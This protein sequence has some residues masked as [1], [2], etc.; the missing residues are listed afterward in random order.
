M[1]GFPQG[2]GLRDFVG[3]HRGFD[4]QVS[5]AFLLADGV[6]AH[7]GDVCAV[8]DVGCPKDRVERGRHGNHDVGFS[9]ALKRHGFKRQIKFCG[10]FGKARQHFWMVVPADDFFETVGFKRMAQ[11]EFRLMARTNHAHNLTVLARQMFDRHR[12]R[13]CCAQCGQ[14]VSANHCGDFSGVGIKQKH[15]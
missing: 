11:L 13:R 5:L 4:D 7:A 10:D 15:G 12:R 14:Q 3:E 8:T 1:L 9:H 2:H 6:G